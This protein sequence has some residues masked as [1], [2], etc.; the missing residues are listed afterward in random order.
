MQSKYYKFSY[1]RQA[2]F[3]LCKQEYEIM[4]FGWYTTYMGLHWI[5]K[6]TNESYRA[7]LQPWRITRI[8]NIFIAGAFSLTS[9]RDLGRLSEWQNATRFTAPVGD[10]KAITIKQLYRNK[11]FWF[12]YHL[13]FAPLGQSVTLIAHL[14]N[15]FITLFIVCLLCTECEGFVWVKPIFCV[16][17]LLLEARW[18]VG[19]SAYL[20]ATFTFHLIPFRSDVAFAE[21]RNSP[22]PLSCSVSVAIKSNCYSCH[23]MCLYLP[24][25][26]SR[27]GIVAAP[28]G[29]VRVIM[30]HW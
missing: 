7:D 29:T 24:V 21:A 20:H 26:I 23:V 18:G 30:C 25:E 10:W 5:M 17:F 27:T 9:W 12:V 4:N 19:E 13:T 11:T 6:L 8:A 28:G 22:V 3:E 16:L 15:C 1:L 2:Y 14:F